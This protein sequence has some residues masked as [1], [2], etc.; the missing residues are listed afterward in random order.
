MTALANERFVDCPFIALLLGTHNNLRPSLSLEA[1]P[2]GIV[3]QVDAAT[4]QELRSDGPFAEAVDDQ[5]RAFRAGT[6][7][8]EAFECNKCKLVHS[9]LS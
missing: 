1:G 5:Q 8:L 7:L 9:P 3:V 4:W 6:C 2:G